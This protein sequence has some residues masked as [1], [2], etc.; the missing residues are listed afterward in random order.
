MYGKNRGD[1]DI[2]GTGLTQ[3][4]REKTNK[5]QPSGE[6]AAR[7]LENMMK[8]KQQRVRLSY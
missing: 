4:A 6:E 5:P 3:A 2:F 1:N 8:A 7:E